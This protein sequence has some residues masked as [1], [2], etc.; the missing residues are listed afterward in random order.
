MSEGFG[1]CWE[2]A[3][4]FNWNLAANKQATGSLIGRESTPVNEMLSKLSCRRRLLSGILSTQ[5]C[6]FG[7]IPAPGSPFHLAIPVHSMKEG[8]FSDDK[9]IRE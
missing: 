2:V 5:R 8:D 7:A 3:R 9:N 6:L 4:A 1:P